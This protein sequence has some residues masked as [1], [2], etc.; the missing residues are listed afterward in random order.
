MLEAQNFGYVG[1]CK[2]FWRRGSFRALYRALGDDPPWSIPV[3]A[4]GLLGRRV[5]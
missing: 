1:N 5:E 3:Q 4:G 2:D